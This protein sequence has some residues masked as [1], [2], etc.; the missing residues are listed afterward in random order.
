M[1]SFLLSSEDTILLLARQGYAAQGRRQ[2]AL[3]HS[4]VPSRKSTSSAISDATLSAENSYQ[5][6]ASKEQVDPIDMPALSTP[7]RAQVDSSLFST[8]PCSPKSPGMLHEQLWPQLQN[9][10]IEEEEGGDGFVI[11]NGL[12]R[13]SMTDAG[14]V[15]QGRPRIVNI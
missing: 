10:I 2:S 6:S 9:T 1:E 15:K 13:L 8:S 5:H 3:R 14:L 12:K 4:A 7:D 11:Y